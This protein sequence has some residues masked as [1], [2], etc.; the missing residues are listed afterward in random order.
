MKKTLTHSILSA[1]KKANREDEI[2]RHGH[3]VGYRKIQESKKA[4]SRQREKMKVKK[5]YS[6]EQ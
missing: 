4:F 3:T 6:D 5:Y 1:I 2:H